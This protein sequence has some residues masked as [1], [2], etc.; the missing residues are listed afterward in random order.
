MARFLILLLLLTLILVG[1]PLAGVALA[2]K[3]LAPYLEF[4]PGSVTVVHAAFSWWAFAGT[5]LLVAVA[6]LPFVSRMVRAR[7]S[8]E[9]SPPPSTRFPW[10]GWLAVIYLSIVW[11][12]A[13]PGGNVALLFGFAV[14]H[15]LSMG[16]Y[17]IL[18]PMMVADYFGREHLGG[19]QGVL[20]PFTT[21]ATAVS[22]ILVATAYDAQGSYFW[23]FFGVMIAYFMASSVIG[24]AKHPRRGHQAP[25]DVAEEPVE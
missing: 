17:F 12:L 25:S 15:G 11:L 21:M 1:L 2:G 10:W 3:P 9:A 5:A 22:P 14:F 8:I 16:G 13:M 7:G 23:G 20:R 24:L 6:V 19:I 4:P 18:H